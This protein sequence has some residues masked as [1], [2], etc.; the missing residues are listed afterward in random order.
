[1]Q[2][3]VK[4]LWRNLLVI[5]ALASIAFLAFIRWRAL[6]ALR[7]AGQELASSQ[8]LA[9]AVH[10]LGR[11]AGSFSGPRAFTSFSAPAVYSAAAVFHGHLFLCGP[12]ELSEY[13]STGAFLHSYRV[14]QELPPS[15]LARIALG[16]LSDSSEPE[17]LISTAGEGVL[18]FN[19]RSF[20]QIRPGDASARAITAILPAAS[21]HLLIGTRK[22]GVLVYDGKRLSPLHPTLATVSVTELA[23]TESDLWV[24]TLDSGVFHWHAGWTEQFREAQG[25]PDAQVQSLVVSGDDA[26]AGTALGVAEFVRGRFTRVLASDAFA[27]ALLVRGRTLVIG[28]IDQ[29]VREVPLDA[30]RLPAERPAGST[31]FGEIAQLFS[32][33]DGVYALARQGLYQRSRRGIGWNKLLESEAEADSRA[34]LA[35]RNISALALDDSGRLWVG[36]FDRGLDIVVP[37]LRDGSQRALHVENEHVF[38]VNRILPTAGPA[39]ATAAPSTAGS[40]GIAVATANGLVLF[41]RTGTQQQVLARSDGLIADHITDV[42]PYRGGLALATPAGLTLLGSGGARS[43]YAFHGLVNNHVYALAVSGDRLLAG[44]LGGLSVLDREAILTSYTT[45]TSALRHNWI[46]AIVPVGREWIVGTYGGGILRLDSNG[47]FQSFDGA[48]DTGA[49]AAA[50][51]FVVNP[52]AMLATDHHVFVGTLGRGL[53]VYNRESDR[54]TR[55]EDGLP[56]TNVTALAAAGGILYVGT[57]NGLVRISEQEMDRGFN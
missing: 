47:H 28:T 43:L 34:V 17:L 50:R 2:S 22:R 24:G 44:T 23:G 3:S 15:P 21:G 7:G 10:P 36:Y 40:G 35:D 9:V 6:D 39:S 57:D 49:D 1:M 27:R 26:Y 29:G 54:W 31:D 38:C 19:A 56:S 52:G 8:N 20:R 42:V 32:S 55:I 51:D 53:Y 5:A 41:D 37:N 25:L 11:A 30:T 12:A 45:A 33:D 13:D 18:A 14:G 4:R 16:V 48:G 46:T